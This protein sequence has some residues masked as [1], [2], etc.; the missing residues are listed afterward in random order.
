MTREGGST[1]SV[2]ERSREREKDGEREMEHVV[3]G[4]DGQ[5]DIA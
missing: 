5:A 2:Y 1:Q 4:T 3:R